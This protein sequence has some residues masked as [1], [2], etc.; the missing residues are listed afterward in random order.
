MIL[1]YMVESFLERSS[2][3][4]PEKIALVCG[5]Q[6]ISYRKLEERANQFAH[7][8][9]SAGVERGDRVAIFLE[10]SAEAAAAIFGT[11]KA[12]AV[13]LLVNHTTKRNKLAYLLVDSEAKA[14]IAAD[15]K[16]GTTNYPQVTMI[17]PA[18]CAK[19]PSTRPRKLCI[20]IDLAALSY[21]CGSTGRPMGVM[22]TH[23]NMISAADS[24]ITYLENGASDVILNV[25]PFSF[26]Y[27]LY[28]LL[29]SCKIG[30][31][32]ILENSFASA[33]AVIQ[34][35]QRER[36]TGFPLVPTISSILLQLDLEKIALPTLRYITSAAAAWPASHITRLRKAFPHVKLYSMYGLTEC[37]RVA[38]LPPD[39]ID[40]RPTSVGTGMPNEEIYL[41]DGEGRR[42]PPGGTG[43]LVVR[44]SNVMKG[45][46]KLPIETAKRLKPGKLP[47]EMVLHTGDLFRTDEEGYLYFVARKDDIIKSRGE[48]VSPREVENVLCQIPEIAEAAVV[49]VP[50]EVLGQAVK[51][52]VVLRTGASLKEREILRKCASKMEEF[53]VPQIIKVVDSLPKSPNGKIDKRTLA[54]AG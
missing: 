33:N 24:I 17:T 27:G 12:G 47:G 37:T 5:T 45:Y 23:H 10:N 34:T 26:T 35:I 43:E 49:G 42:V 40:A 52:F 39:Q 46:W 50:D 54:A 6:R 13:F 41:I 15:R 22:M 29:M 21:T 48:K 19:S 31:T 36:V 38:Y 32:L 14:L 7:T 2:E 25:L 30:G 11:L 28:Q 20:D 1:N 53:M 9:I 18:D 3:R 8:L 51:A 4:D 44:G 16:A